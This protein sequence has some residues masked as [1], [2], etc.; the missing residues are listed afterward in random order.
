MKESIVE[1]TTHDTK[2][3]YRFNGSPAPTRPQIWRVN[4]SI[5]CV[6]N[7]GHTSS[8]VTSLPSSTK[9]SVYLERATLERH[10]LLPV[11]DTKVEEKSVQPLTAEDL[12]L[13]LLEL[14]GVFPVQE[15]G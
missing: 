7:T 5:G 2:K 12:I 3:L 4:L 8:M 15:G 11:I 14:V 13:Q 9:C 6:Y 1:I 10:G